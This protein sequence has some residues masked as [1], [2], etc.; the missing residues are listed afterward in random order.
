L[1]VARPPAARSAARP[2][3]LKRSLTSVTERFGSFTARVAAVRAPA[4][5][6]A[7]PRR[8]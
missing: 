4:R 5:T 3:A 1:T 7:L 2:F 8:T 6:V